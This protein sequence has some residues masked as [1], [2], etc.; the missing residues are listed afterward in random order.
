MVAGEVKDLA[1]ETARATEGI[2]S[3]VE[4]IQNDTRQAIT[5]IAQITHVIGQINQHQTAIA[6]AVE[7]Q[8]VTTQEINRSVTDAARGT[9]AIA[10]DVTGLADAVETS[11]SHSNSSRAT[12]SEERRVGKECVTT[13][14]SRWSPYH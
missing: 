4:A 1:Q 14:R 6:A 2:A 9:R 10:A 11:S 13:C 8:S 3:R 7:E 5:A 12:R